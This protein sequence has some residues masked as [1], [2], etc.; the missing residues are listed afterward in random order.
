MTPFLFVY[1]VIFV[2]VSVD[3]K[4]VT[5]S[6]DSGSGDPTRSLMRA[7]LTL[8]GITEYTGSVDTEVPHK[9]VSPKTSQIPSHK[10]A[11]RG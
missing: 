2:A 3:A 11:A 7:S 4:N 8:E 9:H 6:K 5:A 10:L 1:T